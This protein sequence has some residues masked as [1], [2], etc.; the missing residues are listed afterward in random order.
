MAQNQQFLLDFE[1][2]I[3]KLSQLNAIIQKNVQDKKSF[4]ALVVTRLGEINQKIKDLAGKIIQLKT[5]VDNLQAQVNSNT[6]SIGDKQKEMEQLKTQIVQLTNEKQQLTDNLQNLTK[7]ADAQN[8]ANQQTIDAAEAEIQK[9][10]A[11]NANLKQ[12][13]DAL[14]NEL[15]GRGDL[16]KQHADELQKQSAQFE[17]RTKALIEENTKKIEELTNEITSRDQQITALNDELQKAKDEAQGHLDNID[18]NNNS[19]TANV[20]KLQ[21]EIEQLKQVND[22]LTNRI[23]A[24]TQAINAATQNLDQLSNDAANQQD[25]QNINKAFSDVEESIENISRAIQGQGPKPSVKQTQQSQQGL[26]ANTPIA[27]S[28]Q[29]VPL[30][31]IIAGLTRHNNQIK[32]RDPNNKYAVSL[33]EIN[34][35]TTPQEIEQ[36]LRGIVYKNGNIMGGNKKTKKLRKQ[37]GGFRYNLH[38]KR[39]TITSSSGLGRG[40]GKGRGRKSTKRSS[41]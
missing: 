8:A 28:G 18:K 12:Q 23:V 29:S 32:D 38:T 40:R 7:Q 3:N 41:F 37:K 9:L 1:A 19:I 34:N 10:T 22:D 4:S 33:Q 31:E 16:Q 20:Q 24:A 35:A 15:S 6:A 17:E 13:V 2:S 14:N 21:G 36:A 27:I 11:D 25:L 39:R 5:Q 26:P 30:G